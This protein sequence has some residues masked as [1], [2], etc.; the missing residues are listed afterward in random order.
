MMTPEQDV[1]GRELI[2]Y[3]NG[4]NRCEVIERDDGYLDVND[5]L[6]V[7][8]DS[9]ENWPPHHRKA[10]R[11]AK[12]RV[13]DIGCGAGR[14]ALYLQQKGLRVTGIDVSPLAVKVCRMRGLR[15]AKVVSITQIK[16]ALGRF[17]TVVM[18]AN[19]F[20]LFGN[21]RRARWL[22]KRLHGVTT[23]GAVILAESTDPYSDRNAAHKQYQRRNRDNGRLPGQL[24]VRLRYRQYKTP[25]FDY[26]LVS[27]H[28]MKEIVS[29]TGWRVD[30]FIDSGEPIYV[31]LLKKIRQEEK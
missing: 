6:T 2:D 28:E 25:W 3:M 15:D 12:G 22:L 26:L 17:D 13:L 21:P 11:H 24:R 5:D 9:Y 8:F 16:P 19:N 10:I 31:G 27:K 20:G 14:H 4:S 30:R 1:F 18:L 29:G 7:Y 23:D